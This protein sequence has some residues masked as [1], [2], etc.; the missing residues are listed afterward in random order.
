MHICLKNQFFHSISIKDYI[1][2]GDNKINDRSISKII[3][4]LELS[5]SFNTPDKELLNLIIGPSGYAPSGGQAK[6]LSFA[7]TLCK[8]NVALYLLDEPTSD[9]NKEFREIVLNCIYN[10]SKIKFIL[11]ITHDLSSIRN[12]DEIIKL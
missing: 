5:K 11:S 1:R 4:T 8:R 9:L 2:D 10:L 3:K 12:D 6:L 7:R